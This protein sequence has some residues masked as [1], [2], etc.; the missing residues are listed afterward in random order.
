MDPVTL[1]LL[2]SMIARAIPAAISYFRKEAAILEVLKE[3]VNAQG[4][5]LDV[6]VRLNKKYQVDA[7][8]TLGVDELSGPVIFEI[9][10]TIEN[11]GDLR[12][13]L[14]HLN[15][16]ALVI[17]AKNIIVVVIEDSSVSLKKVINSLSRDYRSQTPFHIWTI[18]REI[19]EMVKR[20]SGKSPPPTTTSAEGAT[21][22]TV[23]AEPPPTLAI[24]AEATPIEKRDTKETW[25]SVRTRF[26]S[27]LGG[28]YRSNDLVLFLGAGVSVE[29]GIPTWNNLLSS[30][31]T[32]L[33]SS[34]SEPGGDAKDVEQTVA[35][36]QRQH[37][38][39]P[40]LIARYIRVGL[41]AEFDKLLSTVL[42]RDLK[43]PLQKHTKL[44]NSIAKICRPTRNG[45][46]IKA[47]VTY[48]FDDLLE[49]RLD[50]LS[51]D[52]FSIYRESDVPKSH[53]LGIYHVHGFL[54][55]D[56]RRREI[57]DSLL[58]FSEEGYHT[59]FM[60]PY[61]WS[62]IVQLNFLRQSTCLLIGLSAQDPNLRRLADFIARRIKS[63]R[64]FVILKRES[65]EADMNSGAQ[66]L[67]DRISHGL[68]EEVLREI[69]FNVLWFESFDEIPGLIESIAQNR[70]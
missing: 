41:G 6:H 46:S 3:Y 61:S 36:L 7:V 49:T 30:L 26:L 59:V 4:K 29:A 16:A 10:K 43:T 12:E 33:V 35:R 51:I 23:L 68:Q 39:S 5:S 11:Q 69:G 31:L 27:E 14:D 24:P 60:D 42:Y 45:P 50:E 52:Y 47:V 38:L 66:E 25:K 34:K 44:L 9:K 56:I 67:Y 62:N 20:F 32:E 2:G 48:N 8:S 40:L 37:G 65:T 63:T 53:E 21:T 17:N 15:N 19:K 28:A 64:H 55:R 70:I 57:A 54:P 58:V 18:D 13:L 22:P 1:T